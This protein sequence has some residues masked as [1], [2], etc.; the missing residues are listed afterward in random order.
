M[1]HAFDLRD[2]FFVILFSELFFEYIQL[3]KINKQPEK[4]KRANRVF[5]NG[6]SSICAEKDTVRKNMPSIF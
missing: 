1:H 6:F 3:K 2:E 4:L 5:C